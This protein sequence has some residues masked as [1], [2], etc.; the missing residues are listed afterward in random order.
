MLFAGIDIGSLA[1]KVC[2]VDEE[3]E[4]VTYLIKK[5]GAKIREI[6]EDAFLECLDNAGL[7]REE[8]EYII[9]TGYGRNLALSGIADEK[10]TEITCHARGAKALFP[11]CHT[12]IDIGGQ[13]SKVMS[14][15]DEG[16]VIRFAMNDKCAAGTGRFLEVMSSALGI[17]LEKMGEVAMKSKNPVNITSVCTVFAE[18]EVISLLASGHET[19]DIVAGLHKAIARRVA[20][21][22]RQVGV[23]EE[24]V[25]TGG[26]AKNVG[27]VRALEEEI[28][29]E[30]KVP[31]EPQIVGAFGAAIIAR[32][33][34][35]NI[36][37]G[38]PS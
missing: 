32:E 38:N 2:I 17:E 5:T 25:M 23:V 22:V 36:P 6:G 31:D 16:K 21:L 24:V 3:A 10:V 34:I 7:K 18:S 29:A 35:L 11:T 8:V 20:G 9:A 19:V 27:V 26:V 33:K 14:L 15:D 4:I 13:D 1:T 12:V 28:G 30:I 37:Q